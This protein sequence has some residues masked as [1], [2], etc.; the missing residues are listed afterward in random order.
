MLRARNAAIFALVLPL[1]ASF[2]CANQGEGERCDRRN[3]NE[4]CESGL[5]CTSKETLKSNADLC[6]PPPPRVP[7]VPQCSPG[8]GGGVTTPDASTSDSGGGLPDA[9]ETPDAEADAAEED[10]ETGDAD[11]EDADALNDAAAD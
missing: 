6:C 9:G 5:V 4:D 7:S 10:A 1:F 2:G 11:L 3:N 8:A